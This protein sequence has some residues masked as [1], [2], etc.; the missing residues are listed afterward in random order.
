[1]DAELTRVAFPGTTIEAINV[2]GA[3]LNHV[4]LR[5]AHLEVVDLCRDLAGSTMQA[6]Q[7]AALAPTLAAE[8]G[9]YLDG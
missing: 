4:D 1:V 9:V 7:F 5:Q 2:Q 8:L 6:D 3:K